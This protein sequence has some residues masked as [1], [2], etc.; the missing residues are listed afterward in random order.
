MAKLL[1]KDKEWLTKMMKSHIIDPLVDRDCA[2]L[3]GHCNC[4]KGFCRRYDSDEASKEYM[5]EL[6]NITKRNF[7]MYPDCERYGLGH[8][9]GNDGTPISCPNKYKDDG[10]KC[11]KRIREEVSSSDTTSE[12]E[13]KL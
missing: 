3:D 5:E 7:C 10:P 4:L 11:E 6:K 9:I 12:I 1:S 8:D 13:S 2:I